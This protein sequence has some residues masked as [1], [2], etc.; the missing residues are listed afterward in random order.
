[1]A[2]ITRDGGASFLE[3][4]IRD[5][6]NIEIVDIVCGSDRRRG[7]GTSMVKE[8]MLFAKQEDAVN[9]FAITRVENEIAQQFYEAVGFECCGILRRFYGH[10]SHALMYRKS[11]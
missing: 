10:K 2:R 7:I 1:M 9:V 6:K 11:V 5:D 3:W 4:S 8:L